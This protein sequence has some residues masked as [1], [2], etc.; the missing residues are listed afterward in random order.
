MSIRP[1]LVAMTN[2]ELHAEYFRVNI[3]LADYETYL[4]T[5]DGRRW[6]FDR[7]AE[8]DRLLLARDAPLTAEEREELE[9]LLEEGRNGDGDQ[10]D[11]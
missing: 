2:A 3:L 10:D 4:Q 6:C 7:L 5:H 8:I 1:K 9:E 11:L